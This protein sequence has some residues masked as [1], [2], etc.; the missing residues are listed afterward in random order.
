[1]LEP[2]IL[3]QLMTNEVYLRKVSP[4]LKA[5][6]FQTKTDKI[7]L[8]II[9]E[10]FVSYNSLIPRSAL[11][12]EV[13]KSKDFSESEYK[14][15]NKYIDNLPCETVDDN[16]LVDSSEAWCKKR[17]LVNAIL[18]SISIIEGKS[19]TAS[20]ESLPQLL[21]DAL[22]VSFDTSVGHD[23]IEDAAARYEYMHAEH[24]RI[25]FDI[26]ILNKITKGG[27]IR[28]TLNATIAE[29]GAGKSA[30][31]CNLASSTIKAGYN[32]LYIT[33]EMAEESIAERIDANLMRSNINDLVY[34]SEDI[35]KTK[36]DRI[37]EKNYGKLIIKEY[38]TSSAHAGHFRALIEELKIKKNF[39][40]DLV[41]I[42]YLNIC[43]SSRVKVGASV[44]TYTYIKFIAEEL[45]GLAVE[46]NVAMWTATQTNRGGFNNSDIEMGDTSESMGF[47]HTLDLY[48]AQMAPEELQEM[49]QMMFKQLKNRYNDPNFYK[50]FI[51]GF[52]RPKMTFYNVEESAQENL[53]GANIATKREK[54]DDKP[55]FDKGSFGSGS[56]SRD[57][58]FNGFD[59]N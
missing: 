20:E 45:R 46:Q 30:F 28:K 57:K 33:M 11:K 38:P 22:A 23:Y 44:N 55:L 39:T 35:F 12:I 37:R 42:D 48:L 2:I 49:N 10:Y 17:A 29:S 34:M 25:P 24:A 18:E 59:F 47:V 53:S 43:C 9:L 5:E 27:L 4:F 31:M 58:D 51:V 6:Y 13:S 41:I 1:M 3:S 19:K 14:T 36:I 32:V 50:R 56:R 40:A 7:L 16:W 15:L 52:D 8:N 26:D 21:S 54:E